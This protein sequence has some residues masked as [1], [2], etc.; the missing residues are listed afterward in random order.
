ML[1]PMLLVPLVVCAM[2][3]GV[4]SDPGGQGSMSTVNDQ[5]KPIGTQYKEKVK[6][7]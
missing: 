4:G 1:P 6:A 2:A 3:G 5:D 7:R